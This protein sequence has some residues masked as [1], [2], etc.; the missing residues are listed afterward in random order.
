MTGLPRGWS[1][2]GATGGKWSHNDG[3]E[4]GVSG[5]DGRAPDSRLG[6]STQRTGADR[7]ERHIP[8][9]GLGFVWGGRNQ[10]GSLHYFLGLEVRPSNL[11]FPCSV[12][13]I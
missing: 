9:R 13:R 6:S 10:F 4:G 12:H 5:K 7:N 1:G 8:A 11:L 2:D 3:L